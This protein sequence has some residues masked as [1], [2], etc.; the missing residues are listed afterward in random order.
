[1]PHIR[2]VSDVWGFAK[3]GKRYWLGWL[4]KWMRK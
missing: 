2:E 3:D 4:G 1:M